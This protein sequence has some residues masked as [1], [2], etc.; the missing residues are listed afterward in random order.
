[1]PLKGIIWNARNKLKK[2]LSLTSPPPPP[3]PPHATL[4][5]YK[6]RGSAYFI[7]CYCI[8]LHICSPPQCSSTSVWRPAHFIGCYCIYLHICSPPQCSST[9]VWRPAHFIGCY[10]IYLHICSPH[11]VL[12]QVYGDQHILLAATVYIYIYVAPHT[13]VLQV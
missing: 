10:C 5:F 13:V 3:P 6:C 9:S 4:L 11:N 7:G 12:L 8:Y 2:I 1:M